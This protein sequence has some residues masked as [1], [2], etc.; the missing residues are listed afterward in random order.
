MVGLYESKLDLY[1]DS[2][3]IYNN[4]QSIK[5]HKIRLFVQ[6]RILDYYQHVRNDCALIIGP[7]EDQN[8]LDP[9]QYGEVNFDTWDIFT[10][11]E[12]RSLRQ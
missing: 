9:Y 1:A 12:Y 8:T 5:F 2:N 4:T 3:R 11:S 10:C 7:K 6:N